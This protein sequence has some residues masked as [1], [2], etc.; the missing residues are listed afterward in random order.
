MTGSWLAF[1]VRQYLRVAVLEALGGGEFS[2]ADHFF[3]ARLKASIVTR[4]IA[5]LPASHSC[6]ARREYPIKEAACSW[7]NPEASRAFLI[8]FGDGFFIC[9][10]VLHNR[11]AP[12]VYCNPRAVANAILVSG[13][14]HDIAVSLRMLRTI[15]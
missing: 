7:V 15:L 10:D 9:F 11:L 8:S 3:R 14:V 6:H 12:S 5:L 1:G 2:G 13:H 4:L